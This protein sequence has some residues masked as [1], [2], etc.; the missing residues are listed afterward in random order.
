MAVIEVGFRNVNKRGEWYTVTGRANGV[1]DVLF[2]NG[3]VRK[4]VSKQAVLSGVRSVKFLT[5]E[6][7]KVSL[8]ERFG[9]LVVIGLE[10]PINPTLLCD[11]GN[12]DKTPRNNLVRGRKTSCGCLPRK[13]TF[14]K[15]WSQFY[16]LIK[17]W[18]PDTEDPNVKKLPCIQFKRGSTDPQTISGYSLVDADFYEQWKEY[19]FIQSKLGYVSLCNSK[20][21]YEKLRKGNTSSKPR[22]AYKLHHLVFGCT[23]FSNY[24][25][26][27]ID[28]NPANNV[29]SNLRLA[30]IQQNSFNQTKRKSETVSKYKGVTFLESKPKPKKSTWK[31]WKASLRAN[32]KD[33]IKYCETELEAAKAY[34]EMAVKYHGE[35]AKLNVIDEGD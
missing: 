35:F 6:E 8:G 5:P 28:S 12:L 27:H 16:A 29:R 18:N 15:F 17:D 20:Q 9:K 26:D 23:N 2:D 11:C 10:D 34:N 19:P 24:V 30:T 33:Y 22:K 14:D 31:P 1:Y 32:C 13:E 3:M 21:V 7:G 25:I 4:G